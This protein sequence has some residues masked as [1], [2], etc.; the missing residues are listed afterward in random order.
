MQSYYNGDSNFI[1]QHNNYQQCN[2]SYP[3]E[4]CQH[5]FCHS[6]LLA[7]LDANTHFARTS[8]QVES[9]VPRFVLVKNK[10]WRYIKQA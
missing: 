9:C 10:K 5:H 6:S 3:S 4:N 2:K 1:T 7:Y 8:G